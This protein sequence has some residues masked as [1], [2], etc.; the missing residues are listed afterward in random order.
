MVT[1]WEQ[2]G[3]EKFINIQRSI[4]KEAVK[5]L[6]PGGSIL[7]STCTFDPGEDEKQVLYLKELDPELKVEA[8]PSFEGFV[9]GNP[10]W[11]ESDDESLRNTYHLFPHK[12]KGEGHYVAL[13]KS[14]SESEKYSSIGEYRINRYKYNIPE[15]EEFL[16]HIKLSDEILEFRNN[17]L[18]LVPEDSPELSGMR[19]MRRGVYLGELKK[20]RFEPSQS[21]AMIMDD[22]SFDNTISFS[23]DDPLVYK[24][25][26]GEETSTNPMATIYAWSGALRKRGEL[27]NLP[28][29]V[30]FADNLEAA[31]VKTLLDGYMT[32]DLVNL[33]TEGIKVQALNSIDFIKKIRNNLEKNY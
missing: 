30:K 27:D 19:I 6:K 3:N 12:I 16:S 33:V 32:K 15:I 17:K 7:Y 25:L 29:L 23:P 28:D 22:K 24:Y 4:L 2:N 21:F 20:N 18:Y 5:M 13:L 11:A 1:A 14:D 31:C 8:I 10:E 26:K 9:P